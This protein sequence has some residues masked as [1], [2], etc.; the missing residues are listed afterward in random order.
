MRTSKYLLSTLKETPADAEVISH[1]LMLRAGMI[2]KVASG[3]YTWLPTGYRVLKK[4][5][6]IVREE[7]NKIGAIEVLMPVVQPADIWQESGRWEQYGPELLRIKDRGNRDFVLGPT[8]EE[9]ITDL[10]RNE[11]SSYKQLPLNF[12]QIQTKFRDEVRP[13]FGVMRSREFIM[14][15]AYSFHTSQ[16]SLQATYDDMYAAYSAI[17]SRIGLDFRAVRAD[18]GSIGGSSSHEFQVL[19]DSG[20]DDI[21]FSTE[22]DYAANI[23]MAEALAPTATLEAATEAMKLIDTPNAKTID[24]LVTQ[25]DLAIEKTVKTLIVKASKESGHEFVALLV[26]GDHTLNEIKAEKLD[27]VAS[28]LEFASE[29]EIRSAIGAGPG[30]LG[31][32]NLTLPIIIDREVAVLSDF[33]AGANIDGKH[34]FNINWQRDV[35]LPRVADIRNV[36][37]GDLSPDGKGTLLI[38]RGIEVGHIFQLGTK[39]SQAMNATVQGED[40]QN[41]VMIMGCYG[42]GV[43]RIVAAAIEQ[44]HDDRG[45]IWPEAI[46]PFTVAIIPMNMHKSEQVQQTA[47]KLY[48]ELQDLGIEVLFDDR[49]ERPGVMFADAELIGIPHTIVIGERNLTNGEVEYKHRASGIKEM[50]KIENLIDFIK[51]KM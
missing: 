47:E 14:K 35:A 32:V 28:P 2:R 5:E 36:V 6:Q 39:Y 23:E 21:V 16:E 41:H 40:G 26:R 43:S 9:V 34:Y 51:N 10:I 50:I 7:M 3:L 30:S 11:V 20:E 46:A 27:I 38:K 45:I 1:Q 12:Y 42:I 17:F 19:A 29:E 31:P 4:V 44:R 37:E 33:S 8:H 24:E 22:S 25:F 15:D 13:R 48:A 18:T 49:K